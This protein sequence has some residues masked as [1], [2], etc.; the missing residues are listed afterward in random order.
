VEIR[1]S[2]PGIDPEDAGRLFE[3]GFRGKTSEGSRGAGI[4]LAIVTRLCELYGWDA[5]IAPRP[6]GGALAILRFNPPRASR[7]TARTPVAASV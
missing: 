4:G 6:E 7:I 3:R 2:G 5:S 1:D